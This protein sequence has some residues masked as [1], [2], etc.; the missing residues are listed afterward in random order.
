[1]KRITTY[2]EYQ[3]LKVLYKKVIIVSVSDDGALIFIRKQKQKVV[4]LDNFH[5]LLNATKTLKISHFSDYI[6]SGGKIK[7]VKL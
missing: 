2:Q 1:M 6:I 3:T 4:S 7:E 5:Y